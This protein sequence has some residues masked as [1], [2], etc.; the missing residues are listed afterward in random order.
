MGQLKDRVAIVTGASAGIGASIATVFAKEGA[1]VV[2]AA[3]RREQLDA[4]ARTIQAAGGTVLAVPT[5]VTVEEQ[6]LNLFRRTQ[7]AFGRLDILVNNAGT[8]V[9]KLTEELTLEEWRRVIDC[10]LT[11]AFLCSREALKIMKRQ[12]S[13]RILNIG[14][15]SA[16]M[17]RAHTAAYATS[18]FGLE[19]LTHSLAVDGRAHGVAACVLQPGNVVTPLWNGREDVM[20]REGAMAPEDLARIAVTMMA[21]PPEINLYEAIV[22]PLTMPMLGR[23]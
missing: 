21:L 6:V 11:G 5:D 7:E 12:R 13:G 19:G 17:P 1:K 4:L 14:S 15:V 9:G 2:L 8:S 22:L 16:K 23:G 20:K 10:N 18:K 3:R